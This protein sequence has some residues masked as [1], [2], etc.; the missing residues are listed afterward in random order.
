[1][2]SLTTQKDFQ[3]ALRLSFCY[4]CGKTFQKED[5]K[6]GDH[7]PPRSCFAKIDRNL[8]LKLPTHVACNHRYQLLDEKI[9]QVIGLKRTHVP[10]VRDRRLKFT[11]FPPAFNYGIVGAL[12]NVDIKGAI[13]RWIV[14]FHAAL[15]REPMQ[16]PAEFAVNT[17]LPTATISG[18]NLRHEPLLPQHALF[19]QLIKANRYARNLDRVRSNNGQL[20]YECVWTQTASG[21]WICVF[22]LDIYDWKDLG[23]QRLPSRGC[24]GYYT[25]QLGQPPANA[26]RA[27]RI[28]VFVPNS[29]PLDAFGP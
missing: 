11:I 7:V 29:E 3:A 6:N 4:L 2:A 23:F 17:P 18:G 8:S 15:Y 26:T 13:R 20:L 12:S 16:C 28:L 21:P 14:G 5:N 24:V 10:T 9:A 19:V 25:A 22:A 27:T 1:M